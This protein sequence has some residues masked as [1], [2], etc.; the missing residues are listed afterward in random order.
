MNVTTINKM[1]IALLGATALLA[2]TAAHAQVADTWTIGDGAADATVTSSNNADVVLNDFG[3]AGAGTGMI[4]SAIDGTK[5]SVSG[6]ALGASASVGFNTTTATDSSLTGNVSALSLGVSAT[7]A[8]NVTNTAAIDVSGGV[9][10]QLNSVSRVALGASAGVSTSATVIG[11]DQVFGYTAPTST[12]SATNDLNA[13]GE[14]TTVF[15]ASSIAGGEVGG[16]GNSVSFAGIGS[17]ASVGASSTILDGSQTGSYNFSLNAD[18]EAPGLNVT[19][20]NTANVTVTGPGATDNATLDNAGIIDAVA[21]T[22]T[23]GNSVSASGIGSSASVSYALTVYGGD[24]TNSAGFGAGIDADGNA[25]LSADPVKIT[26]VNG[27]TYDGTDVT[28]LDTPTTITN[29]TQIGAVEISNVDGSNNSISVAGIGASA[30]YS[31]SVTDMSGAGSAISN[32]LVGG[33]PTLLAANYSAV[34]VDSGIGGATIAGGVNNSVSTA[35]IGAS[36]S[37]SFSLFTK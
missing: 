2:S 20:V 13:D 21:I 32:N 26:S 29:T 34:N 35:A 33:T 11:G 8:G 36:A 18:G 37:Q 23:N 24:V 25:V 14:S 1:K 4:V 19:S 22:G 28:A 17:S 27:A 6:S 7:N 15:M 5:N 10:G 12:V 30:S 3:S 9:L 31:F 16:N